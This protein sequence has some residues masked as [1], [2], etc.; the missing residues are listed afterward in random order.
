MRVRVSRPT[1]VCVCV[2]VCV[3]FYHFVVVAAAL[4]RLVWA[5]S[6]SRCDRLGPRK[7]LL[8]HMTCC[9]TSYWTRRADEQQRGPYRWAPFCHSPLAG[10]HVLCLTSV[11]VSGFI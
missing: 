8:C 6:L 9:V 4:R 2:C 5:L 7:E 1:C 3:F 11:C 10:R